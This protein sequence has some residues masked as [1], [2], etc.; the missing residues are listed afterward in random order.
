MKHK[1]LVLK[2]NLIKAYERANWDFLR[3]VLL[4]I[5]LILEYTNWIMGCIQ[6]TNYV[7]WLN[8]EPTNF[9]KGSRGLRQGFPMSPLLFL[10][11]VGGS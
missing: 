1:S 5:G 7:V 11:I 6:S 3:L 9:F 8:G 10:L 4:Q 2:I